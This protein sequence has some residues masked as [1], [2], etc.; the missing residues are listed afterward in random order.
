M[1]LA[2]DTEQ[3]AAELGALLL[4]K[5]W[6]VTTAESCTGG[7][8]GYYLAAVAGCSGYLDRRFVT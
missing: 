6:F 7:G 3:L 4:R 5:K 2:T 1:A 8:I